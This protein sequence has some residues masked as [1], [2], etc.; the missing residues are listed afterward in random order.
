VAV[1]MLPWLEKEARRRQKATLKQ[2]N[3]LPV[4]AQIP[5]RDTGKSS[6]KAGKLFGISGG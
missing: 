2:G 5:Q 3:K 1:D 4:R 6:D